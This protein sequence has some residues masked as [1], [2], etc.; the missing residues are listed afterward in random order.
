MTPAEN[1]GIN[2]EGQ[3]KCVTVFKMQRK[4][5]VHEYLD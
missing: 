4:I 2:V 5:A 1:S 3:N